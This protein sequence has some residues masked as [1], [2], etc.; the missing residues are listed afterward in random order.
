MRVVNVT[1][2]SDME[3]QEVV[4]YIKYYCRLVL[5]L[6]G[7]IVDKGLVKVWYWLCP[8]KYITLC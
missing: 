7:Q 6:D 8:C 3:T 1:E 2:D 4:L 5:Y